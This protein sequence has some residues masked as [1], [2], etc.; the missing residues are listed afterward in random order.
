MELARGKHENAHRRTRHRRTH[1]WVQIPNPE[2]LAAKIV[3]CF[4]G[5][6]SQDI[7][8]ALE[9]RMSDLYDKTG[10]VSYAYKAANGTWADRFVLR[11]PETKESPN[12]S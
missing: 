8:G 12:G 5:C 7:M 11:D 3:H 10:T 1:R 9:L 4:A 6:T 2:V